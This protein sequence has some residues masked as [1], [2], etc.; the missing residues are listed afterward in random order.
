VVSNRER[1]ASL[2]VTR[3]IEEEIGSIRELL[4]VEPSC[5]LAVFTLRKLG[6]HSQAFDE[7]G[8]DYALRSGMYNELL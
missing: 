8:P 6:E 7:D 5:S 4:S 2:D 3:L 1:L